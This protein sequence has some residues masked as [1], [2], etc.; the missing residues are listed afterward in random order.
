MERQRVNIV[1]QPIMVSCQRCG[2]KFESDFDH[3][4]YCVSVLLR[5]LIAVLRVK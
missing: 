2:V 4:P 5:E 3:E 1:P